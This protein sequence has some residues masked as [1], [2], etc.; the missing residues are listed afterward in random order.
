MPSEPIF[1]W[2]EE[3]PVPDAVFEALGAAS[4][5]WSSMRG[6]GE[7]QAARCMAIGNELIEFLHRKQVPDG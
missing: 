2:S 7:F 5:C 6:T 3:T 4:V 1:T